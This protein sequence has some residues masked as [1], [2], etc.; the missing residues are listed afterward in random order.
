MKL[1][2][3]AARGRLYRLVRPRARSF[4]A[5]GILNAFQ[6]LSS[7]AGDTSST[8][9]ATHQT[10]PHGSLTPPYRSPE[11]KV[12][13]GNTETP[14]AWRNPTR[15]CLLEKFMGDLPTPHSVGYRVRVW[16]A[17]SST[18]NETQAQPR[19]RGTQEAALASILATADIK[20]SRLS[21]WLQRLVRSHCRTQYVTPFMLKS[22][23]SFT[24]RRAPGLKRHCRNA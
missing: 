21:R 12:M 16:R 17:L 8:C 7:S 9:V 10:L 5:H 18:S 11:G 14:P 2:S 6:R 22:I 3:T 20:S 4:L 19:L 24:V 23:G 15:C 1:D 13:I